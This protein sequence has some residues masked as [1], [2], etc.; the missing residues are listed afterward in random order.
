MGAAP[1]SMVLT[2]DSVML[3]REMTPLLAVAAAVLVMA[4]LGSPALPIL[5]ARQPPPRVTQPDLAT[6]LFPIPS[7]LSRP[8]PPATLPT[9]TL[10][11]RQR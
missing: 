10:Q 8:L 4:G 9:Q 5:A 6:T 11:T 7:H 1:V 3:A 2:T